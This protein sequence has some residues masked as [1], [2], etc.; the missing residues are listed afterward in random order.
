MLNYLGPLGL[1]ASLL[2][3][4]GQATV[5][6]IHVDGDRIFRDV[7]TLSADDMEG[8][9]VG[10]AGGKK[11][12][13][14]VLGRLNEAGVKPLGTTFEHPFTFTSRGAGDRTGTNLL[15]VIRGARDAAHYIVVTAHYD[16]IGV[17]NGEV[18]NGADDNASGVA[19]LL[20]LAEHF[21]RNAPEHLY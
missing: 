16:H 1:C 2:A 12:R 3:G 17:R 5:P 4:A 11:A 8:R 10:S 20:A 21:H 13:D 6:A 9:L 7:A 18:F 15:G 19:A 14:Y